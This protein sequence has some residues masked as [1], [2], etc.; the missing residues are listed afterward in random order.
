MFNKITITIVWLLSTSIST[1][2]WAQ[3]SNAVVS[4]ALSAS[5]IK[6]AETSWK[7]SSEHTSSTSGVTHIYFH[8]LVDNIPVR[9]TQSSVHLSEEGKVILSQIKFLTA[10]SEATPV[11]QTTY[12]SASEALKSVA[13]QLGYKQDASF[14]VRLEQRSDPTKLQFSGDDLSQRTIPATLVYVPNATA[15][16]EL[17]W[18]L[19]IL[20]HN[21][22]HWWDVQVNAITG[23]IICKQDRIKWCYEGSASDAMESLDYNRN[24]V[25]MPNYSVTEKNEAIICDDCYEVFAL[26]I[27]SPYYGDRSILESPWHP[28]ASPYG[29]HDIDG[30]PGPES[31]LTEGN[32]IYAVENG[33]HAG[34]QPY[35]QGRLDFTNFPFDQYFSENTQYEDAS[36]TNLFYFSNIMHDV[37]YVY[38]FNEAAGNFQQNNYDRGGFGE[39]RFRAQG[40]RNIDGCGARFG[41]AVEGESPV[42]VLG[43]CGNKDGSYD[44]VVIAH[45]YGHGIVERLVGGPNSMDC[46]GNDEQMTEG[47]ADWFGV[48]LTIEPGD[49]GADPRGIANYYFDRG[50]NSNGIRRRPYSTDFAINRDTYF[51]IL[52]ASIPHGVGAVWAEM[53]WE[54]TWELIA[55]HGFDPDVYNFTGDVNQ[56]AGNVI[57]LALVTESLK[58]MNC[59][60]GF[61]DGRNAILQADR[62]IYNGFNGCFIWNAFARRGLG[63]DAAQG[64]SLSIND[65]FESYQGYVDHATLILEQ[66]TF[67]IENS[68]YQGIEGGIPFGGTYSGPGVTDDGNGISFT[69]DL[70]EA[71]I[72]TH[73]IFYEIQESQCA[74]ASVGSIM[75]EII[76][77]VVP[78]EL[79]CT[80]NDIEVVIPEFSFFRVPDYEAYFNPVDFCSDDL[81]IT[82]TPQ[83]DT[84]LDVGLHPVVLKASDPSGNESTCEFNLRVLRA[85]VD[86]NYQNVDLNALELIKIAPNPTYGELTLDNP[87]EIRIEELEFRD[88]I[89]RLVQTVTV[90]N[91]DMEYQFS[92]A[93]LSSGSYFVTVNIGKANKVLRLMKL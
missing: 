3:D 64:S 93:G 1:M 13:V 69:L 82:Q 42:M 71:G 90:N 49:T 8:Q 87:L 56:D 36:I 61:V 66:T 48:I 27:E 65:G 73:E 30:V 26:P 29:W 46:L 18:E 44:N 91:S 62:A 76:E 41:G 6:A 72:G 17:A 47:W 34:Y 63:I 58:L 39:D 59:E 85:I 84:F 35:G 80:G 22:E 50:I 86:D 31:Q 57:A 12:M 9:E 19:S 54:M 55:E 25:D 78:P 51:S 37:F 32:N 77:D 67:C 24:L 70:E 7:I 21:F 10:I 45:E 43:T 53:L 20:E 81:T 40:Q 15:E 68:I 2:S 74:F 88:M 83:I 4:K 14:K 89:G 38:G 5:G 23:E 60:P 11:S 92:V 79:Y 28:I 16:L 52:G 75:I 33:D